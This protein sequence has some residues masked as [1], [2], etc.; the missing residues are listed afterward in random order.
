MKSVGRHG[1]VVPPPRVHSTIVIV[2]SEPVAAL[3]QTCISYETHGL[4]T[5]NAVECPE[6]RGTS[7]PTTIRET[8]GEHRSWVVASQIVTHGLVIFGVGVSCPSVCSSICLPVAFLGLTQ[9]TCCVMPR[10]HACLYNVIVSHRPNKPV[11]FN[12]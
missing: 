10:S 12:P 7:P 11:D 2:T 8:R 4:A 6:E 9:C 5:I 1:S 3:Y